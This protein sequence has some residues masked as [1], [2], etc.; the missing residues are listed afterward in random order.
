MPGR[1]GPY[2]EGGVWGGVLGGART[3]GSNRARRY[4][5]RPGGAHPLPPRAA[6][7]RRCTVP[8]R[9][10]RVP[11]PLRP[12]IS[13]CPFKSAP[14]DENG[15]AHP[16]AVALLRAGR[17]AVVPLPWRP[18]PR[19]RPRPGAPHSGALCLA[20]HAGGGAC[21]GGRS[22]RGRAEPTGERE[23]PSIGDPMGAP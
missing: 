19:R 1:L 20:A 12:H 8:L 16:A 17:G 23:G 15:G 7:H 10:S 9:E 3:P 2:P 18:L 6:R 11:A 21:G 4:C 22:L 5:A 13:Y 14:P